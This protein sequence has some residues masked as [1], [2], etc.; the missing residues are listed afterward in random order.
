MLETMFHVLQLSRRK[1]GVQPVQPL[2]ELIKAQSSFAAPIGT[3]MKAD[4]MYNSNS[5]E[6]YIVFCLYVFNCLNYTHSFL[7]SLLRF[8][9]LQTN[10]K[11]SSEGF[12][13]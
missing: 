3:L 2:R 7:I 10:I 9:L 8:W 13:S 11:Q 6:I 12:N 1:Q 5:R 4:Y